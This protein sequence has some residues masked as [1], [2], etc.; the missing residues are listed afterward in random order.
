MDKI[1]FVILHYYT[2]EDTKKC[3]SSIQELIDTDNYEIVIVDNASPNHTGEELKKMY[4]NHE[5]IHVIL[6]KENLGFSKGN[7]VGFR[8]AKNELKCNYIAMINNDTYLLQ[9]DFFTVIKEEYKYSHFGV[10]GPK[11]YLPGNKVNIVND[12]LQSLKDLRKYR[13]KVYIK[14]MLNYLGLEDFVLKNK[15]SKKKETSID[16]EKI[17]KRIENVILHGCCLIFSPTYIEKFEGI[18]E[19]TFLYAEED[20]L[21]IKVYT[22]QMIMVYNPKLKIFH[23]ELSST[24][25][26]N[27]NNKRKNRFRYKNLIIANKILEKELKKFYYLRKERKNNGKEECS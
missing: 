1:G 20:L 18:D 13:F 16:L 6:N 27:G 17:N 19:R 10:M 3:V 23:N 15:K 4:D 22:N 26:S 5:K 11:I 8:Y 12:K 2:I 9:D 14:L 7:N 25:A 21:Y 24:K